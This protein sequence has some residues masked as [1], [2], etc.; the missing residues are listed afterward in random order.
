MYGSHP[1]KRML[2]ITLISVFK[3]LTILQENMLN[4][5]MDHF[6]PPASKLRPP[7]MLPLHAEIW[8]Q[9]ETASLQKRFKQ[10]SPSF[11]YHQLKLQT[12]KPDGSELPSYFML[13]PQDHPETIAKLQQ[14]FPQNEAELKLR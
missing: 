3:N 12:Q 2:W 8:Q 7:S 9:L 14:S 4:F 5:C 1:P 11:Q 6:I 10:I 13:P